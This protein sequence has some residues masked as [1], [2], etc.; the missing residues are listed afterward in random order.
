MLCLPPRA[1][2]CSAVAGTGS[3]KALCLHKPQANVQLMQLLAFQ[4]SES[5]VEKILMADMIYTI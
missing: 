1:P 3:L 5:F 2:C 4:V